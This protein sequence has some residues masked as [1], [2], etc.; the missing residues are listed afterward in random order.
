MAID[1]G[2]PAPTTLP[3]GEDGLFTKPAVADYPDYLQAACAEEIAAGHS[4]ST[5]H[6]KAATRAHIESMGY[7]IVADFGDQYSD[8]TGGYTDKTFKLPNPNYYLP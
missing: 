3:N 2:Y 6:Y 1:A 8:L 5:I 4:C 7:E